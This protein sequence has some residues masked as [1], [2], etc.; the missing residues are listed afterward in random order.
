MR[1]IRATVAIVGR[2]NVGKS[3]LFNRLVGR[4]Q[5][6][7]HDRPGVTRDRITGPTT[8]GERPVHLI[9]TGGLQMSEDILGLNEQV[10]LAVEESDLLLLVVD[11][12][13]GRSAGDE[14]VWQALRRYGKPTVLVI[15]K[16]DVKVAEANQAEFFALGISPQVLVSAEHGLGLEELHRAVA[17]LLPEQAVEEGAP[18]L[19]SLAIVGRPNVGK[20]SLLNRFVGAD[21]ALVSP[22]AGTTRDPVDSILEVGE[23]TYRLVDTAGIRRRSQVSGEAEELAVMMARR[24][25]ERAELA[26]L[27]VDAADGITTGDLAIA[28]AAWDLGRAMVILV[29]KWDLVD[30]EARRRL[31][32]SWPRLAE[33]AFEPE[34]VN[35]S[36]ETGRGLDKVFPAVERVRVAYRV[37]L[38]TSEVNR[39]FQR[40]VS[41]HQ[42][43]AERGKPWNLLYAT[44]VKTGPPTFVLFANRSLPRNASY[45]RYLENFLRRELGLSGVPI[46]LKIKTRSRRGDSA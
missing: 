43:P 41:R 25:L 26:L 28:G 7:V 22:L 1:S 23:T 2:P 36:A 9:D 4:R 14:E 5:A 35:L 39:I 20:S 13:E 19:P 30:E 44:Q 10:F 32:D 37:S 11:G 40:A 12:K 15:N 3:T 6:I 33:L 46:H 31:D 29:N 45:R 27:V 18:D 8:L 42:A 34:R 16:G 24:Q 38:A 21:R 17:E